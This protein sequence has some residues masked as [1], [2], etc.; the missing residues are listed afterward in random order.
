MNLNSKKSTRFT[1]TQVLLASAIA[2]LLSCGGPPPGLVRPTTVPVTTAIVISK[3]IPLSQTY[4]GLA[5]SPRSITIDARVEGF[6]LKQEVADGSVTKAN[7]VIYRID[8]RPFEATLAAAAG[9]LAQAVAQRDYARKEME[10]NAPL[11]PANAISQQSFDQLVVNYQ[12][13]DAQVLTSDA[14]VVTAKINLSYCTM[15]SPFPGLLG[16]SDFFEGA[17][18]GNA[19][20]QTLNSLVQIDP[21]WAEF[22]PSATVWPRY[23]AL[24]AKGPLEATVTFDGD[25]TIKATGKVIF[26]DNQV[27][28][29]TGTLMLRVEFT[30]PNLIFRPGVYVKV[31]VALGEEPNIMLVPQD[32]VFA[33]ETDL[34]IWRV[35]ADDT[36]EIVQ[37]QSLKK[38]GTMMALKSGPNIGDRI[39]VDGIQRLKPG[40]KIK[41][42]GAQPTSTPPAAVPAATPAATPPAT[43]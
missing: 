18:V 36:V 1:I 23:S 26:A 2:G 32:S 14:N 7:Q 25:D 24:M 20:S 4:P 27:S 33:R 30:N 41:D 31:E 6:L 8:P 3:N 10:R 17:V 34:Y 15:A 39:V 11:V 35:K 13:A 43:K 28:T 38:I 40:S 37:I 22:S 42:A 16:A 5:V 29:S 12:T 21:M 19:N 9:A